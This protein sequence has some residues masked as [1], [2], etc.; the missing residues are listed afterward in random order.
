MSLDR[1]VGYVRENRV[2]DAFL[3]TGRPP[4]GRSR[5]SGELR[6]RSASGSDRFDDPEGGRVADLLHDLKKATETGDAELWSSL[7]SDDFEQTELW[8]SRRVAAFACLFGGV[9]VC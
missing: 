4:F 9:T 1:E 2:A 6:P 7:R 8:D 3:M 5:V